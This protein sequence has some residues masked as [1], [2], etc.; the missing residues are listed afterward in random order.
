MALN[1]VT[2]SS[3]AYGT[4]ATVTTASISVAAGDMLLACVQAETT[5]S[6]ITDS[7]GGTWTLQKADAFGANGIYYRTFTSRTSLTVSITQSIR[8]YGLGLIVY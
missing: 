2:A 4:G 1:V 6:S 5:L 7:G 8:G 3:W